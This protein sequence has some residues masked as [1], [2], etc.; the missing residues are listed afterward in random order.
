MGNCQTMSVF[1]LLSGE[2]DEFASRRKPFPP[3]ITAVDVTFSL[4]AASFE[5]GPGPLTQTSGSSLSS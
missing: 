4:R 1:S 3:D 5:E 2:L